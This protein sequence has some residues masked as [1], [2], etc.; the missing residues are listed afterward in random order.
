MHQG[1]SAWIRRWTQRSRPLWAG[2]ALGAWWLG[3]FLLPAAPQYPTNY[4]IRRWVATP[5]L[6]LTAVEGII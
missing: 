5:E 2:L 4:S 1:T 3:L 6:D